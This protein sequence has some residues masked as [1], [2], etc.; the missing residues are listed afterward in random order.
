[1]FASIPGYTLIEQLA[2]TARAVVY[3][4]LSKSAPGRPLVLK[5]L[6]EG[7][8][9]ERQKAYFRQRIEHLKV[10]DDPALLTPLACETKGGQ[11]FILQDFF[12]GVPL[13]DWASRQKP[14]PLPSFFTVA[15]GLARAIEKIHDAGI[16]HGGIKPR[17]VLVRPG[18]LD[19]RV[20][21]FI[22]PIDIREVSHFIYDRT[23]VRGTLPYTSPEQTG[24]IGHR[25]DFTTDLYSFG[26][27][28]WELLA[29]RPPFVSSDPL[30][31][32]HAHLAEEPANLHAVSPEI[33]EMLAKIVEKLTLKQPEKRYQSGAGV[34]A[35]LVRCRDELAATGQIRDF[36]LGSR[37]RTHR[38]VF[39]SKMVGRDDE[40]RLI[41]D[42]YEQVTR[43]QFRSV[44]ISGLSGIG[45]TRLIQELQ[46]PIVQHRGYFTSGKF[47]VYQKNIPYSS[48][49]QAFKTLVRTLLTES[50]DHIGRWNGRLTAAVGANGRVLTDVIP[51]LELLIGPQPELAPLPPIES[52]NR[53]LDIFDRFLRCLASEQTP[54]TLFIDDL[55]WCDV[56]SFDFLRMLFDNH[57]DHPHLFFLGAYRHNEVDASHPLT[58]LLRAVREAGR[59]LREIR[60]APLLFQH[61]HEMVSYILDSPPDQTE[62]LATFI[63]DLAEGNPLFVSESLSYLHSEDLLLLDAAQE[64]RWDLA[65]IRDSHMPSTVV[66]LFTSKVNRLPAETIELLRHCACMGNTFSP[67]SLSLIRETTLLGIFETLKAALAQGLIME[68]KNQLQFIHD[69]VQEAVLA[70][71]P[72]ARR[73]EIHAEVGRHLLAAVPEGAN[74]EKL[75]DLFAIV[76]HLN[77]GREPVL[78]RDAAFRLSDINYHAGQKAL[79]SLATDAANDYFRLA[80][81]LLPADAW[82]SAYEPVFEIYRKLAKTELMCGHIEA[83]ERLLDELLNHARTGL[84]K[85]QCLAEQT[86]SLSSIGD[87]IRAIET[88]NRGLAFFEKSLPDDAAEA[89]RRRDEAMRQIDAEGDVWSRILGMPFTSDRKSKIELAFYSELIPDLYMSGLVPQ[90][91]LSA[92]QST[93]HCL[94]GGMDESVIY[95]FSIMGLQLGEAEDFQRAF[96][97]E[98]LARELSARHPSTFGATR[99][100]NGIVWCNMHSRSHPEE[101]VA[102]CLQGIHCGKSCGDLYN[103]GLSYG[104]LMWNLQVQGSNFAVIEEY[105]NECLA[106]SERFRLSFSVRLAKAM[107]AGWIAP[108]KKGY[109]AIPMDD[110]LRRWEAENHV[111]AAGSYY[112]HLALSHYYFGEHEEAHEAL[113]KV[114]RYLTGMT[115]NVLK[116]QWY[117]FQ[118]L[119]ALAR[120]ERDAGAQ[121]AAEV[122]ATIDPLVRKIEAWASM[123]P[124]LPP[125]LALIRAERARLSGGFEEVRSRLLDAVDIAHAA[126]YT[127]LEGY[128]HERLGDLLSEKSAAS[129]RIYYHE[130]A[131]LY[132]R[133]HA[134][135]KELCLV[136]RLPALFE[137][138]EEVRA[139]G[140]AAVPEP[141]EPHVL[142]N[143]DVAYLMKS[144]LAISAEIEASA[145]LRRIMK[146]VLEASGAQHG[147]LLVERDDGLFVCAETHATGDDAFRMPEL[148]FEEAREICKPI[149]RYVHRTRQKVIL[150]DARGEGEFKDNP[151]VQLMPLRSVLCLP[152]IKQSRLVGI[153]YLENRLADSVFNAARTLMTELLTSQAAISLENARL[154]EAEARARALAEAAN[155]AKDEF[156]SVVSHELRTPLTAIVGWLNI[157]QTM[158]LEPKRIERALSVLQR[159]AGALTRI[160][161]DLLDVSRSLTGKLRVDR[162]VIDLRDMIAAAL[163]A[164]HPAADA[165]HIAVDADLGVSPCIVNGDA[166][167]LQ[168]AAWNLLSN[169]VRFTPA[170]GQITVRLEAHEATAEL[171]VTDTGQGITAESLPHVFERFWQQDASTTRAQS[172]LGLGLS[173]VANLVKLHG[174]SCHAASEGLSHGA[175]FTVWLPLVANGVQE[176]IPTA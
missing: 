103:A 5:L 119:N 100:M 125:Y 91:Y 80:L 133:C 151:E 165:K 150:D 166:D 37:D 145:L 169:A 32:I 33:P 138:E 174:G 106:F 7:A 85:A 61:T 40:A 102:Y 167:R 71:I 35:D 92:A 155:C 75:D 144:S 114:R 118:V 44:F 136:E 88:A 10:L 101:I 160:I 24:R 152:V 113:E 41:L 30:E 50:D 87:F 34:H 73:R 2:D 14:V 115:D 111:A 81:E 67:E 38:I 43:G 129:G 159:N 18:S 96:A 123:G 153:L 60:L 53:F 52:R 139:P 132:Q 170:G 95:S 27:V 8:V 76:A 45:K 105:A 168:Q 13:D 64:W 124:L 157:L 156:L 164:V 172:G 97:Y 59:P 108:M 65:K 29:G 116:R 126:R 31:L 107:Q 147:Y 158:P 78:D 161:E 89:D 48:L 130:A 110:E 134:E 12:D 22:T 176:A 26:I 57:R 56:A 74:L 83:S 82:D 11:S 79:S 109:V 122:L 28:L 149:V 6:R 146:V 51:E 42:E 20:I 62:A 137:E 9:S 171:R 117:V 1:V 94:A 98:D 127:F 39:I 128:L 90:L 3:K 148:R 46:R 99:G 19:L 17:N 173:I 120:H 86:T 68:A 15:L 58:R 77:L 21:D 141:L 112:A 66:A 55:Q 175:T 69:R 121:S 36:P 142:P 131:R 154:H 140:P 163:D 84:D 54:L 25:V 23:F 4:A 104:P 63:S 143:L 135:R 72:A 16:I 93:Q 70:S 49:I 47:D 162:R